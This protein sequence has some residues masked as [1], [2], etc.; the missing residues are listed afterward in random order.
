MIK[1]IFSAKKRRRKDKVYK[2]VN[3]ENKFYLRQ[4]ETFIKYHIQ[5]L[6]WKS[7][8][9]MTW[10]KLLGQVALAYPD[11]CVPR[12]PVFR[13]LQRGSLSFSCCWILIAPLECFPEFANWPIA[14]E[15]IHRNY[16]RPPQSVAGK[17][18]Q[19]RHDCTF[20]NKNHI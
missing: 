16:M 7:K 5:R 18:W 14:R 8:H 2:G 19:D 20:W 4:I 17:R 10:W 15:L 3:I 1:S 12:R 13:K 11:M 6:S 9:I